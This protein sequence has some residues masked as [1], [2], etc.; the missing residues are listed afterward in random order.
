MI[1][2][3]FV[4]IHSSRGKFAKGASTFHEKIAQKTTFPSLDIV[5]KHE[6]TTNISL[7]LSEIQRILFVEM[8]ISEDTYAT[9][10]S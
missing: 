2:P 8:S 10:L 9:S 3:D 6:V 5:L 7:K 4:S 1:R